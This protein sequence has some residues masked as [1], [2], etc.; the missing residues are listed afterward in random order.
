MVMDSRDGPLGVAP[1]DAT[2]AVQWF[3]DN[4]VPL[5]PG[6]YHITRPIQ[7]RGGQTACRRGPGY[8]AAL[9]KDARGGVTRW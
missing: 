1:D 8:N 3:V 2:E 6:D 7:L 4:D 9:E 5:P